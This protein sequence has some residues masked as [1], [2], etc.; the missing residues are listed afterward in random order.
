MGRRSYSNET[1]AAVVKAL[2]EGQSISE[3]AEEWDIP[4][5]TVS[6]WSSAA[7][8]EGAS[9]ITTTK[10]EQIGALLVEYLRESLETLR[11]QQE[12]FRD[13]EWLEEQG[14]AEIATLHGVT[15]DKVVRLLEA[16]ARHDAK[17][18]GGIREN[19]QKQIGAG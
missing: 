19:G 13:K 15:T 7:R 6:G 3:V 14:A 8:K 9:S 12:H 4:R 10:K 5:G 18:A 17:A 1:K 11:Q 16:M 2:L